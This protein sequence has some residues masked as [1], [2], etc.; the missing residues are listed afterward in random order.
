MTKKDYSLW[1]QPASEWTNALSTIEVTEEVL[2]QLL[3]DM[4][5]G[6]REELEEQHKQLEKRVK[7]FETPVTRATFNKCVGSAPVHVGPG[8]PRYVCT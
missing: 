3:A 6:Q 7:P 5:E 1:T 8:Q 4:N 2:A